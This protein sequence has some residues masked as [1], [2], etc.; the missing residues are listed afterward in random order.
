MLS[1]EDLAALKNHILKS[2]DAGELTKK[3]LFY[4]LDQSEFLT[5]KTAL[6]F[7][8]NPPT[9]TEEISNVNSELHN[10]LS[11]NGTTN[12]NDF[13]SRLGSKTKLRF[14]FMPG[15]Y[16]TDGEFI[17]PESS[18][19]SSFGTAWIA[20]KHNEEDSIRVTV[21]L[22]TIRAVTLN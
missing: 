17:Y 13:L 12:L 22:T 20:I 6:A 18:N 19:L 3:V 11:S 10:M 21:D 9:P 15:A 16:G 4:L 14:T 7:S 2:T 1:A 8:E 5:K